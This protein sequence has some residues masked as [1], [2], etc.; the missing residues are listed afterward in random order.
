MEVFFV[1]PEGAVRLYRQG[2]LQVPGPVACSSGAKEDG[3]LESFG[4]RATT[5][6]GG[7]GVLRPPGGVGGK[8]AL[9]GTHLVEAASD[10]LVKAHERVGLEPVRVPVVVG[11]R[12]ERVP[13]FQH[14][15]LGA[16]FQGLVGACHKEGGGNVFA[17]RG[18]YL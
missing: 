14:K 8:V 18:R 1:V 9:V 13:Y 17:G 15:E 7:V 2:R 3:V 4:F 6:A 10:K 5:G 16:D 11:G 12:V